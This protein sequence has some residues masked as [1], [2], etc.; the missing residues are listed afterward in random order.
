MVDCK[1]GPEDEQ[2]HQWKDKG[3]ESTNWLTQEDLQFHPG[4]F[5]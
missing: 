5:N 1:Y 2:H 3:E 4:K